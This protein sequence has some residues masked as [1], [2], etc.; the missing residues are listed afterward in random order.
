VV[1]VPLSHYHSKK[2]KQGKQGAGKGNPGSKKASGDIA[3]SIW[4]NFRHY[5]LPRPEV[6][7]MDN[8][9]F[10]LHTRRSVVE[11]LFDAIITDP[12]V[13]FS[14]LIC[15]TQLFTHSFTHSLTRSLNYHSFTH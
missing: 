14:V 5:G 1:E 3:R 11:G 4:D 12:P 15:L 13:S 9:L 7:R 2:R 6:V 10:D 8:H